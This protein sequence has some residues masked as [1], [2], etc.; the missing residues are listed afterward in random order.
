VSEAPEPKRIVDPETERDESATEVRR[1]VDPSVDDANEARRFRALDPPSP[2]RDVWRERVFTGGFAVLALAA[3]VITIVL[4]LRASDALFDG[5]E[6]ELAAR[7]R[8]L[9]EAA[10]VAAAAAEAGAAFDAGDGTAQDPDAGTNDPALMP[11]ENAEPTYDERLWRITRLAKDEN[12]FIVDDT[13]GSRRFYDA[14][15]ASK[16]PRADVNKVIAAFKGVRKL[17]RLPSA[18]K[19]RIALDKADDHLVALELLESPIEVWQA[20][21][22]DDGSFRAEKLEFEREV[23][24]LGVG[25]V[26]ERDLRASVVA[27]GLDDDLIKLVDEML[28]GHV[29]A[30]TL[31]PGVQ[32]RLVVEEE[33]VEK[34]FG[35]YL[36]IHAI[37]VRPGGK[38]KPVRVYRFQPTKKVALGYYSQDGKMPHD[39]SWHSP[40]PLARI[41]SRYNPRRM[42]PVLHVIMPHNGVDYAASTGTPIYA[43]AAGTI[44]SIGDGGPCGN[45]VQVQHDRGLV[46]AYCHM[47]RFAPRLSAGQKVTARQ[48]VGY[49]GRTGRATGP[50]LHFAMKRNDVFFDPLT[51]NFDGVRAVPK[52]YGSLFT[53]RKG[54]LDP[55]LDAIRLA[56]DAPVE[57]IEE[58]EEILDDD[59]PDAGP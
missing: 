28:A 9:A 33:R 1:I 22:H 8:A 40:I 54:E 17:D 12:V 6:S 49:V 35:R 53:Q 36:A 52:K 26:L 41:S 15:L 39:G 18:L 32:L 11:A 27:A 21:E 16:V 44:R 45:M 13:L 50:H 34:K 4:S 58:K 51:L 56:G 24:M 19:L 7:D 25:I 42:H 29:K 5:V 14:L 3:L 31:K 55:I 38:S 10:R 48:L 59:V 30:G 23:R 43:V 37:E 46:S 2:A 57:E 47:S 20:R